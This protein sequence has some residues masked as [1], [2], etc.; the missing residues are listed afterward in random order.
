[1]KGIKAV[2]SF[3]V[4]RLCGDELTSELNPP[5]QV[6][7]R[8]IFHNILQIQGTFFSWL[9]INLDFYEKTMFFI[10]SKQYIK[11]IFMPQLCGV[12]PPKI[13]TLTLVQQ[14]NGHACWIYLMHRIR[15]VN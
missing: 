7:P 14:I 11:Q 15:P 2:L 8:T 5:F 6:N 12:L 13:V 1:M 3:C 9:K 10:T 4:L